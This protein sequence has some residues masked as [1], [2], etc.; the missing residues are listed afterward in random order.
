MNLLAFNKQ[1]FQVL[2]GKYH[3]G[4]SVFP[5]GLMFL[6]YLIMKPFGRWLL[7]YLGIPE[8]SPV[9]DHPNG[10]IWIVIFII[11]VLLLIASSLLLGWFINAVIARIFLGWDADKI[12]R[13]FLFSDVPNE[14]LKDGINI[15]DSIG[16]PNDTWGITRQKGMWNFII[17]KGV[18]GWGIFT[19]FFVAI[20][21][22]LEGYSKHDFFY[23]AWQALL[24]AIAGALLGSTM[25]YLSE[26]E[27]QQNLNNKHPDKANSTDSKSHAAD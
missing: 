2:R 3:F 15:E 14:W 11:V 18:F 25:W 9:K 10:I 12:R 19:Y 17:T 6:S 5:I 13:V 4:L 20:L 8:R 21:P 16:S 22:V 27:Y 24:W 7:G 1:I 26:R 23:F